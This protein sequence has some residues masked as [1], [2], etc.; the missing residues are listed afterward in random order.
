M[1]YPEVRDY[2]ICKEEYYGNN[3]LILKFLSENIGQI[4]RINKFNDD[5]YSFLVEYHDLPKDL[6]RYFS[7]EKLG[8]NMRRMCNNEIVHFSKNKEDLEIMIGARKYNL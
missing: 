3:E 1:K 4:I 6:S 5:N 7:S 2:V 8:I